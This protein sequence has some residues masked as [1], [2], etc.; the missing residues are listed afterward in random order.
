MAVEHPHQHVVKGTQLV[1]GTVRHTHT[2]THTCA[3]LGGVWERGTMAEILSTIKVCL[4][5]TLNFKGGS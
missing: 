3:R 2:H 1:R 5:G 4:I